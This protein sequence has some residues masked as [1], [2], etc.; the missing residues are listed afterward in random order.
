MFWPCAVE[1][2]SPVGETDRYV[3]PSP[4]TLESGA[5]TI[6]VTRWHDPDSPSAA[7]NL[8]PAPNGWTAPHAWAGTASPISWS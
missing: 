4:T 6:P 2:S 5:R 1:I 8:A 7:A 3:S